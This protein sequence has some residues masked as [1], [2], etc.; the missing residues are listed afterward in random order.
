LPHVIDRVLSTDEVKA[1]RDLACV[2]L[3]GTV[4]EIGFGSG[5]NL[6]SYP[7]SV[8]RVLAVEPSDSAWHLAEPRIA[9]VAP[10]VER[11]GLDGQRLDLPDSSVDGVLS[12]YT[13]C[14]IPS[15]MAALSEIRRV[16]K[17]GASLHFLEHGR[18]PEESVRRWQDRLD[19]IQGRL[20]GGCHLA[21]P[22]E[23]LV[24]ASG[25]ELVDLRTEY[26]SGPKW[27]SYLYSGRATRA[28]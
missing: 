5:L 25:L 17:P 14:T 9:A 21:R 27:F 19:P 23:Q 15:V 12:T 26:G 13:L 8:A 18:A 7:A 6:A 24:V 4:L 20:A 10:A 3:T 28:A 22:I 1:R 2:G 11:I 16:L